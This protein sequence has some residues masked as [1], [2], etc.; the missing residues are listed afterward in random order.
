[1][2]KLRKFILASLA[3]EVVA[4]AAQAE[5]AK[6]AAP[7][8]SDVIAASG[9]TVSG[10]AAASYAHSSGYPANIH[11]FDVRHD[12]FQ[13][14]QAGLTVAYQPKE[15]FGALVDVIAGEDAR[16]LHAAEDGNDNSF[17]VR[18]AFIQYATGPLT[19]MAGKFVTLAGAEVINPALNTNFSRSLLFFDCEP[20][21][22][23]GIRATY[24]LSDTFSVTAGI[25]NGWNATS[26]SYGSKTGEIGFGWTPN[27]TFSWTVQGYVGKTDPDF[28][29]NDSTRTLI[30]T[31]LTYNATS[32]L[33]LILNVDVDKWQDALGPDQDAR[34]YGVA[35]YINYA[36]NDQWRISLRAEYVDDQDGFLTGAQQ[37]LK[38]GTI[39]LGYSPAKNIEL[40]FEGR[41]DKAGEDTFFKNRAA[42]APDTDSLTGFAV[43]G[44]FKF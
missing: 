9:L 2:T 29:G 22:H 3:C 18:Q 43:Q 4:M 19:V 10:Y 35:G 1:M 14:D 33:T 21:T 25:N 39:T 5:D 44:V 31:V 41:V 34:W 40:R 28:G 38:E 20:L 6:P 36:I 7:S 32:A 37:K 12:S 17:D 26:T 42:L 23:T 15:G 24:A 27:K 30:D 8:L 13:L 11:Q 16:I